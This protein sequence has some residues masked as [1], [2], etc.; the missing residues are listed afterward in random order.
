MDSFGDDNLVFI[1][2]AHRGTGGDEWKTN[3]DKLSAEG[4]AFEYSATFGQAVNSATGAKKKSI[5]AR[6]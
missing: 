5:R 3:R 2:E 4:F 1:D 6:I